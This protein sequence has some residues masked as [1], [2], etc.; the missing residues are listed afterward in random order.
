M[1]VSWREDLFKA[2]TVYPLFLTAAI[3]QL[4]PP[5]YRPGADFIEMGFFVE[6]F[7][8]CTILSVRVQS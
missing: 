3:S 4:T 7:Q 5:K 2:P 6:E 1:A 8:L